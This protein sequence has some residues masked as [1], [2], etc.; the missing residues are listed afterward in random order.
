M[1]GVVKFLHRQFVVPFSEMMKTFQHNYAQDGGYFPRIRGVLT[2]IARFQEIKYGD[3]VGTDELGNKYYENNRFFVG[4]N[5]WVD[6]NQETWADKWDYNA[7]QITPEWHRW[8]HY[9]TDDP[10]TKVPP[11]QRPFLIKH[12]RNMT[13][14]NDCYVP[15]STTR[16]KIE[17]WKPPN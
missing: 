16:P 1:T 10:P 11:K 8:L 3:H 17:S 9:M 7:S 12:K 4:R 6:Y 13:G 2:Q 5:R 15:Y 14:T